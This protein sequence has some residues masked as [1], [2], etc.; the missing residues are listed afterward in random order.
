MLAPSTKWP[1]DYEYI[2]NK[3]VLMLL[4]LRRAALHSL[5][6]GATRSSQR[7]HRPADAHALHSV[8]ATARA[9]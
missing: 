5:R 6:T 8:S 1:P 2:A 3:R 9:H 4:S 7:W